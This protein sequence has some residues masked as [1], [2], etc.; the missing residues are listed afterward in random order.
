MFRCPKGF[1]QPICLKDL[2]EKKI[3]D[4]LPRIIKQKKKL[5]LLKLRL[6]SG[7][8]DLANRR[9]LGAI[10]QSAKLSVPTPGTDAHGEVS[11]TYIQAGQQWA[12]PT[13][14]QEIRAQVGDGQLKLAE[15][16]S[17]R[18]ALS[19]HLAQLGHQVALFNT[20][21]EVDAPSAQAS[22]RFAAW[23]E[24]L[25]I[26]QEYASGYNLPA[27]ENFFSCAIAPA[28]MGPAKYNHFALLELARIVA[29]GGLVLL[30]FYIG[31]AKSRNTTGAEIL[32]PKTLHHLLEQAGVGGFSPE[33]PDLD[34]SL[35]EIHQAGVQG[36]A[37]GVTMGILVVKVE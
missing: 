25:G 8:N 23:C 35:A 26:Q 7:D 28:A 9:D 20:H 29:P 27:R 31:N 30:N 12:F 15:L 3:A 16:G 34:K 36:I 18:G 37:A 32:R 6:F 4:G 17:G 5:R 13:L 24:T 14:L 33:L 1:A 19:S 21:Y 22:A 10:A 2:D 11:G